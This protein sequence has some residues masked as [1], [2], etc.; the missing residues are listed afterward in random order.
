MKIRDGQVEYLP[1]P[2]PF[3]VT[4]R[5]ARING[6]RL[7][8]VE[9][10][11]RDGEGQGKRVVCMLHGFPEF[12]YSWRHQIPALA[13]AGFHILAPDMRGYNLSDKPP[14]VS[15]YRIDA[16]LGDVLGLIDHTGADRATIIGHDWGGFIAWRLALRHPQAIEKLIVLNAPHPAAF[17]RELRSWG[18]RLKSWYMLFF[19]MPGLAEWV[20]GAGDFDWIARVFRQQPVNAKAFSLEDV[21]RY[22][23]AMA[24]PGALTA[25]LNYY[26]A[27]RH[28]SH[29]IARVDT[30]IRVPVLLLW[31]ERDAYATPRLTEGLDAWVPDLRVERFPDVSH[32]LQ[33]DAPERVNGLILEFLSDVA[34]SHPAY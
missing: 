7:H 13:G 30:L 34:A 18:Q 10:L 3:P 8:Y 12:W 14:G 21:R 24:Q 2:P 29:R 9:A 27:F 15:A 25:G 20:L 23:K 33:N 22:Q 31:G 28:P 16:L 6:I 17:R 4:H 5:F 26:R 11:P 19:Q 32:W 1:G